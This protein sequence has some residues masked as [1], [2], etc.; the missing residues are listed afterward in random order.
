LIHGLLDHVVDG[1]SA[2][3][4]HQQSAVVLHV[5]KVKATDAVVQMA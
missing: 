3:A 1:R 2:D 4:A 5:P